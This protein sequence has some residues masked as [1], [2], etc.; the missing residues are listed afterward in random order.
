MDNPTSW[1]NLGEIQFSEQDI[2]TICDIL[3]DTNPFHRKG[4]VQF[5]MLI[6]KVGALAHKYGKTLGW[7]EKAMVTGGDYA[8]SN[9]VEADCTY[10]CLVHFDP[11]GN[12]YGTVHFKIVNLAMS[13]TSNHHLFMSGKICVKYR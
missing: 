2:K 10:D 9:P 11:S 6:G 12:P 13:E 1:V 5:G 3:G 8:I 4:I 7:F